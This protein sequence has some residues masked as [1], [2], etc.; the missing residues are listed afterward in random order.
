MNGE[1]IFKVHPSDYQKSKK[2]ETNNNK[3]NKKKEKKI[4]KTDGA[5]DTDNK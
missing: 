3:M 2:R 4:K 5:I 1:K